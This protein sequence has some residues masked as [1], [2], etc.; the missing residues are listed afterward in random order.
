MK[1]IEKLEKA[2]FEADAAK[3]YEKYKL[4]INKMKF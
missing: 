4:S 2:A 3:R 1:K